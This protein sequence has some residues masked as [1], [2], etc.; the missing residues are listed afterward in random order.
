M[1]HIDS[2]YLKLFQFSFFVL[3]VFFSTLEHVAPTLFP[4]LQMSNN[5]DA[6]YQSQNLQSCDITS[7]LM[8]RKVTFDS[9]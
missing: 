8:L 3:I 7:A 2:G 4:L 1:R 5:L 6:V 9:G